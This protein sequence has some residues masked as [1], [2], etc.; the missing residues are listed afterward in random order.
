MMRDHVCTVYIC[1]LINRIIKLLFKNISFVHFEQID[2]IY[3]III[4]TLYSLIAIGGSDTVLCINQ[5]TDYLIN[6]YQLNLWYSFTI[7]IHIR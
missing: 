7:L 4:K 5:N 1:N 2:P 3:I 6:I